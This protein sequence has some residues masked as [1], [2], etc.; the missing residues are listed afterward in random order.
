[1]LSR[2]INEDRIGFDK[3]ISALNSLGDTVFDKYVRISSTSA[4][5]HHLESTLDCLDD[6]PIAH[7]SFAVEQQ[8]SYIKMMKGM[9]AE[10]D[11]KMLAAQDGRS[12]LARTQ[13]LFEDAWTIFD[14]DVY[15]NSISLVEDRLENSGVSAE[16]INGKRCLDGGSG[17]GR[18]SVALAKMGASEVIALDFGDKSQQFFS[19]KIKTISSLKKFSD[20]IKNLTG[21]VTDLSQFDDNSFDFVA[22][23]GVLH[24]TNNPI[25]G[26]KEHLRVTS[27]G[28]LLFIYLYGSGGLY[29]DLYDKMR[30]V[31]SR[32]D[33]SDVGRC[34][35]EM[36]LRQG[37]IYT[38]LDNVL[39][40]RTY[41]SI[42]EVV[43]L[44]EETHEIEWWECNG[45][46]VWDSPSETVRSKFGSLLLGSE[47]EVRIVVRKGRKKSV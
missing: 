17:T 39:A 47:G 32:Y 26:L 4:M 9:Y 21:D 13:Q 37:F 8:L 29:W 40:P 18:L 44:C 6:D 38:Y 45:S 34:M 28:G 23:N 2:E 31:M 5:T 7:L 14:E 25:G 27:E 1:M 33:S 42:S 10:A 11:Q 46:T 24:H 41:H 43:A 12:S 36:G 19:Q 20:V 35:I 30:P 16:R 22:T 15:L 3:Y